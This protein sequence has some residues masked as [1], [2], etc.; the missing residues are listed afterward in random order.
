MTA[1]LEAGSAFTPEQLS[2]E[3]RAIRGA[4]SAFVERE[5]LSRRAAVEGKDYATH[6]ALLERL[7]ADGYLGIDVPE[8]YGG[9]GLDRISSLVVNEAIATAGSFAVTYSAHS[10]IGTL[11]TVFFGT[12]AQKR[13]YLPGLADGTRVGAYCL[14]EPSAGGAPTSSSSPGS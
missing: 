5:V 4:V 9:A 8:A 7:G 10:G 13:R 12:D 3:H 11:P 14:T 2:D 1:P 6:R